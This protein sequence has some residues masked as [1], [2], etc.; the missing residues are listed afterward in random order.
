MAPGL[1]SLGIS[2]DHGLTAE[3]LQSSAARRDP[4][5]ASVW[6]DAPYLCVSGR[7]NSIKRNYPGL[8]CELIHSP[9]RFT[10]ANAVDPLAGVPHCAAKVEKKGIYRGWK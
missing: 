8:R 2:T 10:G 6:L 9:A 5:L 3:C 7:C 4:R 1:S